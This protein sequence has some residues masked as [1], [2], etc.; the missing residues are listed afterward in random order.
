MAVL[1]RQVLQGQALTL[2]GLGTERSAEQTGMSPLSPAM[3]FES[4]LKEKSL[5]SDVC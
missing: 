3:S 5:D 1:L 4:Q 2:E